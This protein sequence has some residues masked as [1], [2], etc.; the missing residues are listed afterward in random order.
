VPCGTFAGQPCLDPGVKGSLKVPSLFAMG[1]YDVPLSQSVTLSLGAG[2]GAVW[3]D[4]DAHTVG[5]LNN[6]TASRFN[7]VNSTDTV[8]G[9]RASADLTFGT[10]PIKYLLGYSYTR[11][12]RA[13]LAGQ[14]A[15]TTFTFNPRLSSHQLTGGV[16]LAF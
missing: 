7:M 11:T 5:R 1:Y 12:S 16:R 10:G 8:F 2:V 3:L 14:G 4:L 13:G 6:G 15:Y 9:G